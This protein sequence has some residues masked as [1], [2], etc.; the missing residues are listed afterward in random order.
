[1]VIFF[2]RL[3]L[4]CGSSIAQKLGYIHIKDSSFIY[5][6]YIMSTL[7]KRKRGQ[8]DVVPFFFACRVTLIYDDV[9]LT[10][11]QWLRGTSEAYVV[12]RET[13]KHLHVHALFHSKKSID[14][15]RKSLSRSF[16][17]H[18]QFQRDYAERGRG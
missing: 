12:G 6:S 10:F 8:G 17:E 7:S 16:K 3:F 18:A 1:M 9:L 14:A 13:A 11:L 2:R 5:L 4:A 15:L